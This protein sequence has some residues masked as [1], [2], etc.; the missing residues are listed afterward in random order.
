VT[1]N[2]LEHFVL[3]QLYTFLILFCRFGAC[4][5]VLPG[6]G[7][8]YV[9][10]R[11]RLLLALAISAMLTPLMEASMPPISSNSLALGLL[12][13]SEIL[14]GVFF[15]LIAR[16]LI[17]AM[18]V[19]GTIIANQASLAIA[20]IFEASVGMQSTIVAN[21]F[22][23]TAI[24]LVFV[25][26]LHHLMLTGMIQSYV[27]FPAGKWPNAED[28]Y[29]MYAQ[30]VSAMFMIGVQFS[31]PHILVSLL[32]YLVGGVMTRLMPT[33]QVFFVAMPAQILIA[34]VLIILIISPMMLMYMAYIED[35]LLLWTSSLGE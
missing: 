20:S 21:F 35:H 15:G 10:P 11:I 25:L 5:M 34:F 8:A 7:D 18:H 31:M 6:F 19:A 29:T 13:I 3:S 2:L 4:L 22:T 24:C 1:I 12:L 26:N 30:N 27:V 28:M 33:F 16:M 14:V 9:M 17:S 32:V 23:L